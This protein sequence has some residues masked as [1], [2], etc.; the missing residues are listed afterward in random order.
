MC[1]YARVVPAL[2]GVM[3]GQAVLYAHKVGVFVR[4]MNERGVLGL[5]R[6]KAITRASSYFR[7]ALLRIVAVVV[8]MGGLMVILAGGLFYVEAVCRTLWCTV[9]VLFLRVLSRI[10]HCFF[11]SIIRKIRTTHGQVYRRS[12]SHTRGRPVF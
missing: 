7:W 11:G 8:I 2:V 10:L 4:V 5:G 3:P 1:I 6:Y 9:Q 12:F